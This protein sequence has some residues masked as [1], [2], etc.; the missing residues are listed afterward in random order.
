MSLF[1]SHDTDKLLDLCLALL[2]AIAFKRVLNAGG[3]MIVK[4]DGL[5]A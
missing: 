1:A 4:D 5:K 2:K 3:N